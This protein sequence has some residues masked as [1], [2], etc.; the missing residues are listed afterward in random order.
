MPK[1]SVLRSVT[2]ILAYI[3]DDIVLCPLSE[4]RALLLTAG[5]ESAE[6]L[7]NTCH[8]VFG[9]NIGI[10]IRK[11]CI[12][13]VNDCDSLIE[14]ADELFQENN[15]DIII[16]NASENVTAVEYLAEHVSVDSIEERAFLSNLAQHS[17]FIYNHLY[18]RYRSY[19]RLS[20][21]KEDHSPA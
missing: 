6:S 21:Q 8:Q 16:C 3:Y 14:H 9:A 12:Y 2:E 13:M 7:L 4:E 15:A 19:I 11:A 1:N 18:K 10:A 17:R 5:N 20:K